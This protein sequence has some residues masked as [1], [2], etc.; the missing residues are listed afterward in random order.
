[1][2]IAVPA[3]PPPV[4][5][6]RSGGSK[7]R[8]SATQPVLGPWVRAQAVNLTR[9]TTALRDFTRE[10]FGTGPEAPTDGHVQ[11]VNLLLAQL[12]GGLTRHARRMIQ[13]AAAARH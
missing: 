8:T 10:E 3:S 12:R 1:M 4:A 11:A 13:L 7:R 2:T 5:L 9:H 6:H